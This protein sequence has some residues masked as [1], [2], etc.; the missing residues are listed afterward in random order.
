[1]NTGNMAHAPVRNW[2]SGWICLALGL[3]FICPYVR[4][5]DICVLAGDYLGL[6]A[7]LDTAAS[8]NED[9]LIMLQSGQYDIP[10]NVEIHS[11]SAGPHDLIIAGGYTEFAGD[12]CGGIISNDARTTVLNGG[13]RFN[14]WLPVGP[15]SMTLK[16]LTITGVFNASINEDAITV[17][18]SANTMGS[19]RISNAIFAGN[20][21]VG[22]SAISI[23]ST[24]SV[25]IENSLFY[26]ND[27]LSG[28]PSIQTVVNRPDNGFCVAIVQS[29]FTKNTSASPN[30]YIASNTCQTLLANDIFWGNPG[31]DLQFAAPVHIENSDVTNLSDLN[32][33]FASHVLSLDPLFNS[34]LSL[35]DFSPLRD[36]GVLGGFFF[37]NGD[38]DVGGSTR[39][40]GSSPD[41]GA[42]EIEDV[43]FAHPFD[44]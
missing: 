38:Y 29:T 32:G 22:S 34:D 43:I 25:L 24:N 44:W 33:T 3:A 16:T 9:N 12:A 28:L 36:F 7:A 18:G 21:S 19:V 11:T 14:L 41:V 6:Q 26:Q 17:F 13:K 40:Y 35:S 42:F 23:S 30:I 31:G 8:N 20:V 5:A 10:G 27:T 37:D 4:A 2:R 39:I 1:M 15:G